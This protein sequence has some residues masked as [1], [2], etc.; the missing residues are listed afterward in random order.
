[1]YL[2][3][4][5]H[6]FLVVTARIYIVDIYNDLPLSVFL[7]FIYFLIFFFFFFFFFSFFS[8]FRN[9]LGMS[10]AYM[11]M[12]LAEYE[13]IV[14]FISWLILNHFFTISLVTSFYV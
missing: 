7:F 4:D 3:I 14:S 11:Y 2:T 5:L 9:I 13:Y 8:I 1:M 12:I 6:E 10:L